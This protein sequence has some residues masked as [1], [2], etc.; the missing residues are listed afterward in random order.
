MP[1]NA[2]MILV[3]S[4][5]EQVDAWLYVYWGEINAEQAELFKYRKFQF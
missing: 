5:S 4:G 3:S 2:S 1:K